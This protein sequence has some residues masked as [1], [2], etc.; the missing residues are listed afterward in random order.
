MRSRSNIETYRYCSANYRYRCTAGKQL[1]PVQ[2]SH[3]FARSHPLG[4]SPNLSPVVPVPVALLAV[5]W[6]GVLL[7]VLNTDMLVLQLW[8]SIVHSY[9]TCSR[10][11][12]LLGLAVQ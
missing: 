10:G 1:V 5:L 4:L 3:L 9:S 8:H 2:C 12:F 7:N 11:L 6:L